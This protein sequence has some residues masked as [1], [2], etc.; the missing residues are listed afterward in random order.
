M[1][2]ALLFFGC[3]KNN[4]VS[5]TADNSSSAQS[6]A[7]FGASTMY[8]TI[9]ATVLGTSSVADSGGIVHDSLRNIALLDSLKVYLSLSDAQFLQ[10]KTFGDTLFAELKAIRSLEQSKQISRDSSHTL[11]DQ[12]R[13]Q[14]LTSVQSILTSGQLT[15]FSTWQSL[16]WNNPQGGNGKGGPCGPGNSTKPD[17]SAAPGQP[18]WPD[19]TGHSFTPDSTKLHHPSDGSDSTGIFKPDS[20]GHGFQGGFGGRGKH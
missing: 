16:Y 1:L 4:P 15:L 3:S 5:S 14:F 8:N 12:A 9:T 7:L 20:A 18:A 2:V 17:T 6:T 10:V 11:V 13:S 19:S